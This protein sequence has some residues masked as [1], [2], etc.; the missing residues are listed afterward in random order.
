VRSQINVE[1][2]QLQRQIATDNK[3]DGLIDIWTPLLKASG[4]LNATLGGSAS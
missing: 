3:A 4:G 1:F 2:P